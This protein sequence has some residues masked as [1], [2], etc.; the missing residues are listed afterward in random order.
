MLFM[1]SATRRADAVAALLALIVTGFLPLTS[2]LIVHVLMAL[3]P[4]FHVLFVA[5]A[6]IGHLHLH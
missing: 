3:L 1:G 4:C 5:T 6:L 2:V